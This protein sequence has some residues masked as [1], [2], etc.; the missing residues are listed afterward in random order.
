MYTRVCVSQLIN[1]ALSPNIPAFN[2]FSG[3]ISI[4]KKELW[5]GKQETL[6]FGAPQRVTEKIV[7]LKQRTPKLYYSL[8]TREKIKQNSQQKQD[9][10]LY[11][12]ECRTRTSKQST[13]NKG[14]LQNGN[15]TSLFISSTGIYITSQAVLKQDPQTTLR[16]AADCA[17]V[18]YC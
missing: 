15:E 5:C 13:L 6:L 10:E 17:I 9:F 12:S 1:P 16:S 8:I 18:I 3:V 14:P 2:K 11:T 4:I 7:V